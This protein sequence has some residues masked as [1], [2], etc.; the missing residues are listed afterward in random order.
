MI[1]EDHRTNST[2]PSRY[3]QYDVK[4]SDS[5]VRLKIRFQ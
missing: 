1:L 3:E 5:I 2:P 4:E